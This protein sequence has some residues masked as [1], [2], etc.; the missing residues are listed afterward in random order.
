MFNNVGNISYIT[1][2]KGIYDK[3]V[4]NPSVRYGRNS[5]QNYYSY[6][7]EFAKPLPKVPLEEIRE[8][9]GLNFTPEDNAKFDSNMKKIDS[10]LKKTDKY[11]KTMPMIDFK[12]KYMPGKVDYKNINK[13]A[14]LGASFQELGKKVSVSV[15]EMTSKIQ[16]QFG[17]VFTARAFDLNNDGQ[18]DISENATAILMEDMLSTDS[19][20]L[21]ARNINGEITNKGHSAFINYL[22]MS[23]SET[24]KEQAT[25]LHKLFQLGEAQEEF[26][27]T[28][29]N[30]A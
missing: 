14:L 12:H 6:I 30:M 11:L 13:M 19:G 8:L 1:G 18:I 15:Q 10:G 4:E 23:S 20:S 25:K 22:T 2:G 24:T 7:R 26:I 29:N 17:N 28:P 21:D 27:Q 5:M 9:S 3:R 16:S